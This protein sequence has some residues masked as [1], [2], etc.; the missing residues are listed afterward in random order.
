MGFFAPSR[1]EL[2]VRYAAAARALHPYGFVVD[3]RYARG[4]EAYEPFVLGAAPQEYYVGAYGTIEGVRV[5][6]FE[7]GYRASDN[8][9]ASSWNTK[10]VVAIHHPWVNGGASFQP[11]YKE[12]IGIG[13]K[14]LDAILWIPPLT[15]VKALQAVIAAINPDR[16]VGDE[17]FDRYYVVRAESDEAARRAITPALREVVLRTGF[18]GIVEL[19]P[20]VLLYMPFVLKLD[21]ENAVPAIGMS[22][23]FLGALSPRPV[24]PMR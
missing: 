14:I 4:L 21:G 24:H 5:E 18:N 9:G 15:I 3:P 8:A 13:P 1:E 23:A 2:E 20:G 19:R 17:E 22:A 11:D 10:L 12:W 16:L 7:Y 6:A